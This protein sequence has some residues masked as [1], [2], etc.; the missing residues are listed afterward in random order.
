MTEPP[1][2]RD[3]ATVEIIDTGNGLLV[4]R[5]T[6]FTQASPAEIQ[7]GQSPNPN[8]HA[9]DLGDLHAILDSIRITAWPSA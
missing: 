4:L 5:A 1:G 2:R 3:R 9:G 6:D 7:G 8:A